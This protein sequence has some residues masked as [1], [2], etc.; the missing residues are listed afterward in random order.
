MKYR[1]KTI[2]NDE[3]YSIKIFKPSI[4]SLFYGNLRRMNFHEK[5]RFFITLLSGYKI[6]YLFKGDE[7]IGYCVVSKGSNLRYPFATKKDIII[8]PYFIKENHKGQFLIYQKQ[9]DNM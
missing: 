5:I 7:D 3:F 4:Y 6:Y 1:L 2:Y 8:G 9:N